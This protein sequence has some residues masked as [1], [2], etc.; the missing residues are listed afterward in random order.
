MLEPRFSD[1]SNA[2]STPIGT[3]NPIMNAPNGFSIA[4]Q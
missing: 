3:R 2:I 1:V 4:R